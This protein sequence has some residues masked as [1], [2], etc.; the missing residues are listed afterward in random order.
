M[1]LKPILL[2]SHTLRPKGVGGRVLAG[3]HQCPSGQKYMSQALSFVLFVTKL[4]SFA[5][6]MCVVG[7]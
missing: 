2:Y 5:L 4:H 3:V 1:S 7:A 6:W